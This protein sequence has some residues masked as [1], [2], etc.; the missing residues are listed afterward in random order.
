MKPIW[1]VALCFLPWVCGASEISEPIVPQ[2]VGVNIHF[3]T[4]HERELD[5]IQA[6]GFKFIRMDFSWTETERAKGQYDWSGY[7]QLLDHLDQHG[8]KAILILDY[9]NPLYEPSVTCTNPMNNQLHTAVAAPQ[10]PESVAAFVRWA[11]AGVRHFRGRHVLWEIWNEP[12]IEFWSPVPNAQQYAT[13]ALATCKA[14]RQAAPEATIIGPASSTFPWDFLETLFKSGALQYLDAVSVHPYRR[15]SLP[16]ESAAAD[17]HRLRQ[18]I[19]RYA[20]A[21]RKGKIPILSGEWGYASS[22]RKGVSLETQAAFAIR[23]QLFNLLEGV[24]M[25]NWYDWRNDGQDPAEPEDNYGTT[26][27]DLKPKPAYIAFQVMTR[28]LS[29]YRIRR[30]LTVGTQQDFVLE[31]AN[32]A[33]ERKLAAWTIGEPHPLIVEVSGARAADIKAVT[34]QGADAPVQFQSGRLTLELTTA[35]QYVALGSQL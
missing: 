29:G 23:Q 32:V 4:G 13:L 8:L 16:P 28:Q 20:P 22:T 17:F 9:S 6:A 15:A 3:V 31:C 14:I 21:S 25:S 19:D 12:N 34:G 11:S 7:D 33:G 1:R 35:P 18:L 30:R 5:L 10:H 2:G 24:P 26:Y 27:P